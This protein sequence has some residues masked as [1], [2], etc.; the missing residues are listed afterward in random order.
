M[1]IYEVD[2]TNILL[3]TNAAYIPYYKNK[4]RYMVLY[5]GAGSGKSVFAGQKMLYR[6]I[7]EMPLKPHRFLVVRK[8]AKT[9][10][11]SAYSLFKEIELNWDLDG[12]LDYNKTDMSITCENGNQILFAGLDDV[13]KLKSI[14]GISSVW[15]EEATE[16]NPQDF[17]QL[18]LRLRGKTQY[19]KQIILSFNPV[20][21]YSWL[22]KRFFD[23]KVENAAIL[24]TTY[25]DNRFIDE[26]YAQVVEGLKE[27]DPTY[28]QI[29]ALGEWGSP[30]GLIYNNWRLTSE[31][32]TSGV[33]TYGLDFG[34]NNPTA[35]IEVRE[36]DGEIYLRELIYQTHLTNSEL[37][38]KMKQM[39][40]S[41][42]IYCDSAEPNRIQELRAAGFIAMPAHKDVAK[43]IDH[44]KS[45]KLRI[46]SE[47]AN[48]IKE[49]QSYK[50]REDKDGRILD[51][52][53]KYQ[54]HLCDAMRYA[55]YTGTKSEYVA[56]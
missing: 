1:N 44:V 17:T 7:S 32:S 25:K 52:P 33:V 50:W 9:L 37:I 42:R 39:R 53:V 20:S 29:Y 48:L 19:Y 30:K 12:L 18:D 47:S 10:R 54:D 45:R 6:L 4:S 11:N 49:L 31:M 56:W 8:V 13:E 22:K 55:L 23:T 43:G 40:I 21:A 38:D 34:Y 2:L 14:T 5:G 36:Y 46:Y 3:Y 51:E 41:G 15:V 24:K 27:Q 16:L 26:A 28:Y 35:L